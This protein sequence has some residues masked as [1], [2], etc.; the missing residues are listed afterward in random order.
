MK[1]SRPRG[2]RSGAA[3][4]LLSG[5]VVMAESG[6]NLAKAD[7]PRLEPVPGGIARWGWRKGRRAVTEMFLS[8]NRTDPGA[9][10]HLDFQV[11][12]FW[13]LNL[14][15]RA[16]QRLRGRKPGRQR[17][18]GTNGRTRGVKETARCKER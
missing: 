5:S 8:A 4:A 17:R 14:C 12:A 2:M 3:M 11:S 9:V 7:S 6:V 13:E 16:N 15:N 1:A 10:R 18:V